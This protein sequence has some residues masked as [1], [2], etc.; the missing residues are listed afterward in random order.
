MRKKL[1]PEIEQRRIEGLANDGPYGAFRL[2]HP[3]T[4]RRLNVIASDGRDWVESDLPLPAWEHVSVSAQYGVPTWAEMCWIKKQFWEPEDWVVQF[5][6]AQS[7]YVNIHPNVLHLWRPV[8]GVGM[9]FP[10]KECV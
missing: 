5:H 7:E 10:P 9:T 1:D 3:D 6:P 4:G 8:G 2:T